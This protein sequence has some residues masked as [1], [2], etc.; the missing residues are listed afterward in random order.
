MRYLLKKNT[1]FA[2]LVIGG[3]ILLVCK[4]VQAVP[5]IH[6]AV[7]GK[8][9]NNGSSTAPVASLK[10]AQE[11]ARKARPSTVILHKGVWFL[12][13]PILFTE[14]DSDT[15]WQA[16]LGD[17]VVLSGGRAIRGWTDQGN[18]LWSAPVP[19]ADTCYFR[20]LFVNGMRATRARTP[21]GSSADPLLRLLD[22]DRG[23]PERPETAKVE[24]RQLGEWKNLTDVE[25]VVFKN[26]ATYHKRLQAVDVTTG[27]CTFMP[28]HSTY[29]GRNQPTSKRFYY[30]ENAREMLDEPGE[31]YL[32]R[33]EKVVYYKPR[34]GETLSTAE[35]IAPKIPHVLLIQG[36]AAKPVRNLTFKGL[37][38]SHGCDHF[39]E[40]GHHGNQAGRI[41]NMEGP[42]ALV[43]GL[44][45]QNC[46]LIGC[47]IAHSGGTGVELSI[48]AR[49][50]RL[51]GNHIY[52]LACNGIDLGHDDK[53][54]KNGLPTAE[55]IPENNA[56]I[57]NLVQ[58]CGQVYRGA[59]GIVVTHA[60][61]TL[62][63]HN[64]VTDHPYSG[65][66]VGWVW[67]S[68]ETLNRE[69][70]IE[71]NHIHNVMKDVADG[72]GLYTL[73]NQPGTIIRYNHI[74]DVRRSKYAHHSPN[75]GL[76]FDSG[77][78]N[79][80]VQ[81]NLV[82]DCAGGPLRLNGPKREDFT[83]VDNA[84][85]SDS[86]LK[87]VEG[88][89]G[90]ALAPKTFLQTK[91][92]EV[93]EPEQLTLMAWINL[94]AEAKDPTARYYIANKNNDEWCDGFFGLVMSGNIPGVYFNIGGRKSNRINLQAEN[95]TCSADTWHHL[96]M[97][98][99]NKKLLFY[100]D[101]KQVAEKELNK[102]RKPSKGPFAIGR[103]ADL[104]NA[105]NFPGR[106]D[107][108]RLYGTALRAEDIALVA[109]KPVES[110]NSEN[111]SFRWDFEEGGGDNTALL[112][113]RSK[114]GLDATWKNQI[115]R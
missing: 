4:T 67:G 32:D 74:H 52:D 107:D 22:F 103:R 66:T 106:I 17:K 96:A 114:A 104:R 78:K 35:V 27:L 11:L 58:T 54:D 25:M 7:G 18:G 50:N 43:K 51:E 39:P 90:K 16:A 81:S 44:Y 49:G 10:R 60:R 37:T 91:P 108:V 42:P 8:D 19:D 38:L 93:P 61:K 89:I 105:A 47:T 88:K 53:K 14:A 40:A 72:G 87:L 20:H 92:E 79:F 3:F 31:W 48:A 26:W 21:N 29:A 13:E 65:V 71:W 110:P 97:S 111:L 69:N 82:Y 30:F 45:L 64:E 99:D 84:L 15:T 28:P 94:P 95:V 46:A 70:I 83:F 6:V 101:G 24:P 23:T 41:Y 55:T 57:N 73:G 33:S 76:F 113:V 98:Y 59:C 102:V 1:R 36:T 77:S 12:S 75:N 100:F 62:I 56:I 68:Q 115:V 34:A 85:L 63:A 5:E 109:A 2:T 86:T 9:D 112:D 80:L